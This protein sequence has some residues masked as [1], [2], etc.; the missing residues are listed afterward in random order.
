MTVT[1]QA[2]PTTSLPWRPIAIV[3]L[4]ATLLAASV[5]VFLAAQP[6]PAPWFGPATNGLIAYESGGTLFAVDPATSEKT[7]LAADADGWTGPWFSPDGRS[8]LLAREPTASTV[9]FAV[10]SAD[11][12]CAPGHHPGAAP[13]RRVRRLLA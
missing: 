4:L 10:M 1:T 8:I 5:G 2:V 12:G 9:E 13:R 11:G 7:V 3:A 6:K